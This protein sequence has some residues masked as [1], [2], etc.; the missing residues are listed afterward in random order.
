MILNDVVQNYLRNGF[1]MHTTLSRKRTGGN[2]NLETTF[3]WDG[4]DCLYLSGYPGKRDWVA[5]MASNPQVVVHIYCG[6]VIWDI[7]SYATVLRDRDER[8]PHLLNFINHWAIN[9]KNCIWW[10]GDFFPRR[11]P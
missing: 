11:K 2:Y 1:V 3:V 6:E 7:Y 9:Y 10:S 5:N 8:I 4:A